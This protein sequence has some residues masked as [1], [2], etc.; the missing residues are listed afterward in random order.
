MTNPRSPAREPDEQADPKSRPLETS[1]ERGRRIRK[2]VFE[3]I[4]ATRGGFA[5]SD[6]ISREELYERRDR[7]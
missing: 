5:A 2:E 3:G 6:N 1:R 4:R 7:G